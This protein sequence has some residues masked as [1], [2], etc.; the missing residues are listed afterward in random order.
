M[1][2][3]SSSRWKFLV[4]ALMLGAAMGLFHAPETLTAG[5]RSL[6]LDSVRPGTSALQWSFAESRGW[7]ERMSRVEVDTD[8]V[9]ELEEELEAER[10][11]TRSALAQSALLSEQLRDALK[12]GSSPHEST[13]GKPLFTPELLRASVLGDGT[14]TLWREG[15]LIDKGSA[16]GLT[17]SL[18]VLDEGRTLID[19]G[20]DSGVELEQDVYAGRTVVGR[21]A[22][23]GRWTSSVER[24]TDKHYRGLARI[25]RKTASGLVLGPEGIIEGDGS[26]TC[27]LR[28]I[29]VTDSV[30]V[31][32]EVYTGGRDGRI[33]SLMYYGKVV[34]A[35]LNDGST[36]WEI[37]VQPAIDDA[38]L[39][40]VNV[41]RTR[42]NPHRMLAQ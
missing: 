15:K 42:L 9:A 22:T 19:Q 10:A 31:G 20:S 4:A 11:A 18:L 23:V 25:A 5:L 12:N 37:R 16:D 2:K 36:A 35:R 41:L 21:I 30:E 3:P 39:N 17:E 29:P 8:R 14:R 32:D 13:P 34:E 40:T 1:R 27:R 38:H 24:V 26:N 33:R 6:V 7:L 28:D